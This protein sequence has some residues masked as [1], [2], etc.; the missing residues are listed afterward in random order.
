MFLNICN[1]LDII[2]MSYTNTVFQLT[3]LIF[4]KII[5]N[6]WELLRYIKEEL[7]SAKINLH[8]ILLI[9]ASSSLMIFI[10]YFILRSISFVNVHNPCFSTKNNNYLLSHFSIL[11]IKL[12]SSILLVLFDRFLGFSIHYF[13]II[14]YIYNY[15]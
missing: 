8:Y 3:V 1:C 13:V 15:F 10:I 14:Q 2:Q 12:S 11:L 5:Y 7:R 9:Q 4:S 6:E